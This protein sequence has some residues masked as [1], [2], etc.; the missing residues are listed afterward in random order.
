ME[1]VDNSYFEREARN[2][3]VNVR[4]T[5]IYIYHIKLGDENPSVADSRTGLTE[6]T[7]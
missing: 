7:E 2:P 4:N 5:R 6:V 1:L 3:L